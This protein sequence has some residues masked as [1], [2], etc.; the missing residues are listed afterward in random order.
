MKAILTGQATSQISEVLTRN[1]DDAGVAPLVLPETSSRRALDW[2]RTLRK[3]VA[4]CLVLSLG[5]ILAYHFYL[6]WTVGRI[7][8][9]EPNKTILFFETLMSLAIITFGVDLI[10]RD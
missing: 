10:V 6:F 9:E 8:I 5:I 3:L 1:P 2:S 4:G 7:F